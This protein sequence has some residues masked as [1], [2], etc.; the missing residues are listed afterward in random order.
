MDYQKIRDNIDQFKLLINSRR[1]VY[2]IKN[3]LNIYLSTKILDQQLI[4]GLNEAIKQIE[5]KILLL[6]GI[7]NVSDDNFHEYENLLLDILYSY[8]RI[9]YLDNIREFD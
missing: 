3:N 2:E 6:Y 4:D 7:I 8:R 1:K 5:I 9:C